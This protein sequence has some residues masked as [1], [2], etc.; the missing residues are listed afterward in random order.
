M[1][2][3]DQRTM[4]RS[5]AVRVLTDAIEKAREQVTRAMTDEQREAVRFITNDERTSHDIAPKTV[6]DELDIEQGSTWGKVAT[7]LSH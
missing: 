1:G 6:C 3:K 2:D 5:E 4:D 7:L